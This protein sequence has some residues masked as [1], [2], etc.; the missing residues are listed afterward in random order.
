MKQVSPHSLD[1][2][3]GWHL[4]DAYAE[5][6]EDINQYVIIIK[7]YNILSFCDLNGIF[8]LIYT[9]RF[10][11]DTLTE[12]DS[13]ITAELADRLKQPLLVREYLKAAFSDQ[14]CKVL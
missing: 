2:D 3:L 9:C 6:M 4:R 7:T 12:W 10:E 11:N 5:A 8:D 14:H 13:N 1:G